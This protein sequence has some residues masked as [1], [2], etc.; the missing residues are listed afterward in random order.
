MYRALTRAAASVSS[1]SVGSPL[2]RGFPFIAGPDS[3]AR[4][5][6]KTPNGWNVWPVAGCW[7]VRAGP[8]AGRGTARFLPVCLAARR[9]A[10]V[11]SRGLKGG[12]PAVLLLRKNK[13]AYIALPPS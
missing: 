10:G 13:H 5:V 2:S 12:T 4:R 3:V 8:G 1:L 11:G 7:P 6:T 9:A